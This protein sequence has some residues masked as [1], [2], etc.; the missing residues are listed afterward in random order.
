M[1]LADYRPKF[2]KCDERIAYIESEINGLLKRLAMLWEMPYGGQCL[3]KV[4][5]GLP[6]GRARFRLGPSLSAVSQSLVPH[7]APQGMVGQAFDLVW[8][9]PF[10]RTALL[11]R[12]RLGSLGPAERFEALDNP[13]VEPPAPLE[14]EAVVGHLVRQGMREGI[15][16]LREQPRLVEKLGGL[17]VRQVT[18]QTAFR[19]LSD[20]L[21]YG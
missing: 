7:L 4:C 16:V 20:S 10:G 12:S 18:L 9:L 6:V 11:P 17:Q 19:Q 1:K 14:Q 3:L 15:V 21:Q 13:G 8:V 5:N 2:S